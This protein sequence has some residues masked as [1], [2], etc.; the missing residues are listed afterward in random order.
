MG[1]ETNAHVWTRRARVCN[2][3]VA[4]RI[5]SRRRLGSPRVV[6]VPISNASSCD[7]AVRRPPR[8][9]SSRAHLRGPEA[10]FPR[11][12]PEPLARG[13]VGS[14]RRSRRR[15]AALEGF[16]ILEA[17]PRVPRG[18]ASRRVG[19]DRA[20]RE[21]TGGDD[22]RAPSERRRAEAPGVVTPALARAAA[23]A[24]EAEAL[25]RRRRP[26]AAERGGGGR[27]RRRGRRRPA[28][29]VRVERAEIVGSGAS[30]PDLGAERYAHGGAREPL[31]GG[32]EREGTVAGGSERARAGEVEERSYRCM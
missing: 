9:V 26:D 8:P 6:I 22:A 17:P 23:S 13:R 15:A 27:F 10:G 31:G 14:R 21:D 11:G 32:R 19:D 25:L 18:D 29:A 1:R 3:I 28:L 4:R 5:V 20:A 24:A 2:S 7:P 16:E 12:F 30:T